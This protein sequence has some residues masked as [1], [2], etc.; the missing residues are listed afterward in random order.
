MDAKSSTNMKI[1]IKFIMYIFYAQ[2]LIVTARDPLPIS[3]FTL[4]L[5]SITRFREKLRKLFVIQRGHFERW[6]RQA[7]L[8][9]YSQRMLILVTIKH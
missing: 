5:L 3:F 4:R 1:V 9:K 7:C 6:T 2:H 8:Y